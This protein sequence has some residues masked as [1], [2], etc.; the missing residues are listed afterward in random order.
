M[1]APARP[2]EYVERPALH[3]ERLAVARPP[4]RVVDLAE[5]RKRQPLITSPREREIRPEVVE[6]RIGEERL[7]GE[8]DRAFEILRER[9]SAITYRDFEDAFR[10]GTS[11]WS[12]Y[13][14]ARLRLS[15]RPADLAPNRGLLSPLLFASDLSIRSNVELTVPE[16]ITLYQIGNASLSASASLPTLRAVVF[17]VSETLALQP[18]E[19]A[20]AETLASLSAND[21]IAL[22]ISD[23]ES[24]TTQLARQIERIE[25]NARQ[26]SAARIALARKRIEA[27]LDQI[28]Y[29]RLAA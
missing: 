22:L 4:G 17:T 14:P 3:V 13:S 6:L 10:R 9:D 15:G 19:E 21:N 12:I 11:V 7:L 20:R 18:T 2:I 24:T 23:L 28:A 25:R 1:A 27:I 29:E 16:I 26:E 8:R 5:A